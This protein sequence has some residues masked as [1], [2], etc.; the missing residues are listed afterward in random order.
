MTRHVLKLLLLWIPVWVYAESF[1]R[2]AEQRNIIFDRIGTEQGLSQD[3]VMS[4]VQDSH[5]FIWVGTGEGL[6][7]FD[8]FQFETYYRIEGSKG[9]LSHD[10]IWSLLVDSSGKLWVGTDAG[11]NVYDESKKEF[12][13]YQLGESTNDVI[14]K[15]AEDKN[16]NIWIGTSSGISKIPKNGVVERYVYDPN[17]GGLGQ[18]EVRAL[19]ISKSNIL[20]IGTQQ[21]G[22]FTFS[23]QTSRFDAVVLDNEGKKILA[24]NHVRDILIDR[25]ENVW[26]ATFNGGLSVIENGTG[27]STRFHT[28]RKQSSPLSSNRVRSLLEDRNGDIWIGTDSGLQ[29][30]LPQTREFITYQLDLTDPRSI[31]DNAIFDIYQDRGGVIWVGTFN[32]I[33]KWNATIELFPYFKRTA[34]GTG[35]VPGD[36]VT[37]F[38]EDSENSTWIGTL[39]GL[40]YWDASNGT[41][42]SFSASELG[43]SDRRV[44]SL[45][46]V[47]GTVWVGTMAGG[48][49]VLKE[50]KVEKT[51]RQVP[52][53]PTS[54]SSNAIT[55][56]YQD[57]KG[58]AWVATFGGGVNMYIGD[59]MFRRFPDPD[60]TL[61]AFPDKRCMDILED[62]GGNIWIATDGGG[63]VILD[64]NTGN[65]R[66]LMHDPDNP[67]SLVS[68]NNLNLLLTKDGV[69][70]GSVDKGLS[71]YDIDSGKITRLSKKDGLASDAIYGLLQDD[72]GYIWVSGGK[73]LSKLDPRTKEFTLFDS[74]HGLQSSDFNSGAYAKF[75]DSSLAFGGN[76][77]FNVFY[78]DR[79]RLNR[80]RPPVLLTGF[81]LFNERVDLGSPID[82]LENIE[83]DYNDS[84]IGFEFA[85]LDYTA[86]KKNQFRYKLEGFDRD[87]VNH[88]GNR[89]VTYTNLDAGSY[90]FHVQGS[91]NDGVWNE[92]GASVTVLVNPAPWRTIWA[93]AL[94]LFLL[95]MGFYLLF[96]YNS[97]RLQREAERRYSERLQLYIES[98]EEASDCI[99]IA[100]STGTL[101]YAN[102][103][104]TEGLKKSPAEVIGESLWNVL[105]QNDYD[106]AV[107]KEELE[108][109]G[110]YHG[111]IQF[112]SDPKKPV[113][114][115]VTIAAVQQ[116]SNSDLAYVGIARDVTERKITEAELEDYRKNLETLVEE[117]T[118]ALQK[119]IEENKAIQAHLADSLQEKE[120]LIKE[121]HHRVKNNMQVIS[122]LLSIQAE[123]AGDAH[124]A[125]LLNESQQ[126]IKSMALI[127]ETLY[128]AKDM[129]KIDFQEYIETL[130]TSLSRSYSA[131]GVSVHVAVNVDNILLDLETAVPCGLVINE[132]VSN[133]LKH[134]F[135]GHEGMGIIDICFTT[136]DCYYDLKI[137]D[138]G[139]GLPI[140]FD[141]SKNSSMGMEIVSILTTQLEGHLSAYSDS[142][143]VF[144]IRFPRSEH[145]RQ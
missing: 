56:I 49:D 109:V 6:S 117:R 145:V 19:T 129:L 110:R 41:L 11:L 72:E 114:H 84:V 103:T 34:S 112:G 45:G 53:Q 48:V 15:I 66:V 88:Q 115:E 107:A 60:N 144:E 87:W 78:P 47:D 82:E 137:S 73:G 134:A 25:N 75:S 105:F 43:L 64:P 96:R 16:Q 8:G 27:L 80:Y 58:R 10:T 62:R 121:V 116:S 127:H 125:H 81:K 44:M 46:R 2:L 69:W 36:N 21:S 139:M 68:N 76:N 67:A 17:V 30:W 4:F 136:N 102:N 89:E 65:T 61:G 50:G 23:P 95:A 91:N 55:R 138:N 20:W 100:D 143:A 13:L 51:F 29:L 97:V 31:S 101:M 130:T 9:S 118:V 86:P 124:Y 83:L 141:L 18:G 128:Q 133:A 126:R 93:Y 39:S 85:S 52:N 7:K 14:Y 70:I 37:A 24:D 142:G 113:T 57:S 111:E 59:G 94:Y 77:G 108:S 120:L 98:L 92:E 42:K 38:V 63:V 140:D 135:N 26:I 32:G 122:S 71:Y 12:S 3:L 119:E 106:V 22:V 131:P 90:I 123:G 104:I 74:T 33:S 99:L 79:I 40:M 28:E 5:G 35:I 1:Q 132:L 54:L